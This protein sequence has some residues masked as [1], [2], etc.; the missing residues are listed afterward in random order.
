[1]AER[2][3]IYKDSDGIRKTLLWDDEDPDRFVIKTEQVLDDILDGIARDR[4]VP[5]K[6]DNR[7][8]ARLPVFV[9]EDLVKRGIAGDEDRFK[10]WLNGPEADPWRIYR[11]RL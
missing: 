11:G 4:D 8:A 3:R 1:M 2:Q 7:L 9:Y 10:A 6:G 5:Q